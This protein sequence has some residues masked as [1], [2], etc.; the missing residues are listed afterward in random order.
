MSSSSIT[1]TCKDWIST[2]TVDN[3]PDNFLDKDVLAKL[4]RTMSEVH[5]QQADLR[6]VLFTTKGKN[7]SAG[8]DYTS[9][10]RMS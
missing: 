2:V 1:V 3:P 4:N 7:F 9:F 5:S 6:V 8:I 10:A